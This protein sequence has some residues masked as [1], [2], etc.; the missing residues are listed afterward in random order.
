MIESELQRMLAQ[1]P[2]HP[3]DGLQA[4]IWAGVAEQER[5]ARLSRRLLALQSAVLIAVVTGSLVAGAHFRQTATRDP[6][7]IFSPHMALS[8]STRLSEPRP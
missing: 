4:D 7:D 3:L 5:R 6:L 1:P 2:D 8:V